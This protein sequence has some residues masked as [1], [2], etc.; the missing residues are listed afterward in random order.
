MIRLSLHL[1]AREVSAEAF[2][3]IWVLAFWSEEREDG[4]EGEE[5][6]GEGGSYRRLETDRTEGEV[7]LRAEREREVSKRQRS[8]RG[9]SSPVAGFGWSTT[10]S[11]LLPDGLVM[12]QLLP[13]PL[14]E[15]VWRET[16][17]RGRVEALRLSTSS[18]RGGG[19]RDTSRGWDT[20]LR[21]NSLLDRTRLEEGRRGS[22]GEKG[23]ETTEPR[24]WRERERGGRVSGKRGKGRRTCSS[25]TWRIFSQRMELSHRSSLT[26]RRELFE[27]ERFLWLVS[28]IE[29]QKKSQE[30]VERG[31]REEHGS[32]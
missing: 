31:E 1:L 10:E 24:G 6:G 4:K 15:N 32:L 17:K 25:E 8:G 30:Q 29:Q 14:L 18:G 19:K 13:S 12:D 9:K 7:A 5:K 2:L 26:R 20:C 23:E 3:H 22:Q 27:E 11:L 16:L 28:W 21:L